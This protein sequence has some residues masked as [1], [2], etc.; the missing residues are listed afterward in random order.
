M[1]NHA[2]NPRFR[3]GMRDTWRILWPYV[4][5]NFFQARRDERDVIVLQGQLDRWVA[6][7][8]GRRIHGRSA[9]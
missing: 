8:A 2:D 3:L 5:R 7:I 9:A 1:P 4:K 6:E